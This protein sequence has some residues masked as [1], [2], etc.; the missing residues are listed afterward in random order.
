MFDGG[1]SLPLLAVGA[2]LALIFGKKDK[3]SRRRRNPAGRGR[4]AVA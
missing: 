3:A 4:R 2:V 1:G